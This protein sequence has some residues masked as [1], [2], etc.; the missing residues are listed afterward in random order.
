MVVVKSG[1][2]SPLKRITMI[3]KVDFKTKEYSI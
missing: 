1:R 3:L 2:Q